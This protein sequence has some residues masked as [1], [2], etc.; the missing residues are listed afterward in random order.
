VS[1]EG[2]TREEKVRRSARRVSEDRSQKPAQ[3]G[4]VWRGQGVMA[5]VR[6]WGRSC[7]VSALRLCGGGQSA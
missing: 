4:R 7:C 2:E 5:P 1:C 6:L 3:E